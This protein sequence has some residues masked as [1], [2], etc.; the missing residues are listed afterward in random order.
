[1]D[2]HGLVITDIWIEPFQMLVFRIQIIKEI[3]IQ[4]YKR[5]LLDIFNQKPLIAYDISFYIPNSII[6]RIIHRNIYRSIQTIG[7]NFIYSN[8]RWKNFMN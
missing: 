4:P 3:L 5:L 2:L 6:G 1:M 7:F 8:K